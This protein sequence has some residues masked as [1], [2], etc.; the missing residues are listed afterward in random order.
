MAHQMPYTKPKAYGGWNGANHFEGITFTGFKTRTAEGK[1]QSMI[2]IESHASDIV[3]P[4]I[5][6]DSK[7][8]DCD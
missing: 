6:F 1:R 4:G 3:N 5:F 8:V 2:S 7:F